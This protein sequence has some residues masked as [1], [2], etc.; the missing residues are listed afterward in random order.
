MTFKQRYGL[1]TNWKERIFIVQL[2][3]LMQ[4]SKNK[5][6]R[7]QDTAEYFERSKS[8]V[9]ENISLAENID[10]IT[11][12]KSREEALITLKGIV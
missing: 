9:S 4:L 6:H 11:E 5:N 3:H 10:S 12:C 1:A 7:L 2:Y 8:W